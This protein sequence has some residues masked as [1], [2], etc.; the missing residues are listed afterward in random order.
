VSGAFSHLVFDAHVFYT[1][2]VAGGAG[3]KKRR[4]VPNFDTDEPRVEHLERSEQDAKR[5]PVKAKREKVVRHVR[6]RPE[7][8]V[9]PKPWSLEA[10]RA[11]RL[12]PDR[13]QEPPLEFLFQALEAAHVGN[14]V[15]EGLTA[16]AIE[17]RRQLEA[18]RERAD[19][20]AMI[21]LIT[22]MT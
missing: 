4:Y 19:E 20:E 8:Y 18:A 10:F 12:Q 3:Y 16:L 17:E 6:H 22:E 14:A 11:L 2:A 15:Y 9:V 13:S 1:D 5:E 21:R 7:R